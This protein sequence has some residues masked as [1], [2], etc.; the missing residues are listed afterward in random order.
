MVNLDHT[1]PMPTTRQTVEIGLITRRSLVQIQ[2]PPL[3]HRWSAR[4]VHRALGAD[5][6][7]SYPA[8]GR[9]SRVTL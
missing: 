6:K 4:L 9:G 8:T 3:R 5:A 7:I 2:P 1:G